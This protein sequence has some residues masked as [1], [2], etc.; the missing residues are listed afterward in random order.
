MQTWGRFE[1]EPED[2]D[3]VWPLELWLSR[4]DALPEDDTW[5]AS[6]AGAR[7][8]HA[9]RALRSLTDAWRRVPLG[10]AGQTRI[11]PVGQT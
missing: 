10:G 11:K 2:T 3:D 6:G 7:G 9:R 8:F 4:E 5:H 1:L